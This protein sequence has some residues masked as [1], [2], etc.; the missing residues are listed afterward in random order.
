MNKSLV[1]NSIFYMIYNILNMLF[2]FLTSMYVARVILPA[3]IGEIAYAQNI[4]SYFSILAFLGIPTYGVREIA[5]VRNNKNEL[6]A[7]FSELFLINLISS[8]I[9]SFAYYTLIFITPS[10]REHIA[11]Y[12]I[13]GITVILNMLNISWLYEGLEEFGFISLRNAVFKLIMFMLVVCSV[14]SRQ[15]VLRYVA[16]TVLGVAG[17][18]IIN[19]VHANR[20]LRF[21][22]KNLNLV[23]HLRSIFIL[24]A[25]NLAIEIYT[26][27]DTTMLGIMSAKENVAF[28]YYASKINKILLQITNT[29]TMVLVPRISLYYKEHKTNEFNQLLT[30]TLKI[31]I[32]TS[33]PMIIGLQF[34]SDFLFSHFFG[35]SYTVSAAVERILCFVLVISPVGYLLGSRVMLVSNNESKMTICVGAGAIVN[36]VGNY[37]LIQKYN[38]FGAAIASVISES[39]VMLMYVYQGKKVFRLYEFK[40][41]ILKVIIAGICEIAVLLFCNQILYESW[42]KILIEIIAA[43]CVYIAL[44]ILSGESVTKEYIS[45]ILNR[46]L[47]KT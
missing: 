14:R 46:L 11:L 5:K 6:S 12:F 31:I 2:P 44:L 10:F 8:V 24:A 32:I 23:R 9:F 43:G 47:S 29:V 33:V 17:N 3:D 13:I 41:T 40:T 27:I 15:D 26:L 37:F 16:I 22:R 34:T 20:Y 45:R 19:V 30:K 36:I 38:E 42:E 1:K 25:V 18:N 35:S 4:V 39:I 28:Y 21:Q 7:V